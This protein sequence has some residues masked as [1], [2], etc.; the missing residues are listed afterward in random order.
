MKVLVV[1]DHEI[2]RDGM[3]LQLEQLSSSCEVAEAGTCA[4]AVTM[5]ENVAFDLVL[6]DL[7]L[8][9]SVGV[10]TLR[11]FRRASPATPVVVL[12]G[13]TGQ[14]IV[15]QAIDE[16]AM[17]FIPKASSRREI[18]GALEM[19]LAGGV[20]IPREGWAEDGRITPDP[21]EAKGITLR[22]T[23]RQLEVLR[24]AIQGKPNKTIAAELDLSVHTVK[25]HLSAAMRVLG[26]NNRTEA[27]F[28]A[29]QLGLVV[30]N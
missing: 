10:D 15:M 3:K 9:D 5:S 12:S 30:S 23:D 13:V 28:R 7:T 25:A 1:D 8:P 20:F 27:V 29:A 2:A 4:Q 17:G 22:L 6:L 16:G 26:V 19:I 21:A 24:A 14:E 11:W 18:V